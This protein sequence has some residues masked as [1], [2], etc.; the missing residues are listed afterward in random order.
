MWGKKNLCGD[1]WAERERE[2]EGS[3]VDWR[4]TGGGKDVE[5]GRVDPLRITA[6]PVDVKRKEVNL[7]SSGSE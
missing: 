3:G 1:A 2:F 5:Q 4:E 7:Q 6:S